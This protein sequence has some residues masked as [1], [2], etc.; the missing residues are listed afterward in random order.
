M[1]VCIVL[2]SWQNHCESALGSFDEC[3]QKQNKTTPFQSP[4]TTLSQKTRWAYSTTFPS[5][6]G[7]RMSEWR[8]DVPCRGI[9]VELI[10]SVSDQ[11]SDDGRGVVSTVDKYQPRL[12]IIH[13][14]VTVAALHQ[15]TGRVHQWP[16]PTHCK[17][18][19]VTGCNT[20]NLHLNM[21]VGWKIN[22]LESH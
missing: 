1:Y 14:R 10:Q 16:R 15:C 12:F 5:P 13:T 8:T 3:R 17:H 6:H 20:G 21:L 19:T 2:L 4:L 11:L 7:A 18:Q 22:Y 9:G